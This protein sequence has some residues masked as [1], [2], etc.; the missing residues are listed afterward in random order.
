M[1]RTAIAVLLI[2]FVLGVWSGQQLAFAQAK[3]FPTKQ[4][5][6]LICFDPGGQSDRTARQQQAHL[7][8]LLGQQIIID[9]KVGGGGALGWKE[10]ARAKPDGYTFAGFNIPHI[11]LQPMQQDVGYK[12]DQIV[13]VVTFQRTPL[14]LAV[15][16]KSPYK[17][18]KEFVEFAK[19]NPEKITVGGSAV[20]SG[21]HFATLRMEKLTGIKITYV[22]FTGAAPQMTAFLGGHTDAC[23]GNS[24]DLTKFKD[25]LRVLGFA[26]EER[27]PEFPDAPTFKELGFDMVEGTERGVAVP[28][29]TP[30]EVIDK[31]E[32][33]FMQI[34][35]DPEIQKEMKAQGF[36]PLAMGY[37][38]SK[39]NIEKLTKIYAELAKE[40]KK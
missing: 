4:L 24:D 3:P 2:T 13:P 33:A 22:P 28:P 5:T 8:R 29:G 6:Y 7:A 11:I 14:A 38:E 32:A 9:Y 18:L 31:L 36:V 15:L 37:A 39:T 1:K 16:E 25:K 19:K 10:L 30:K 17:T 20:F 23:M 35:K 40:I 26:T 21:P 12:T 34:A 27:F